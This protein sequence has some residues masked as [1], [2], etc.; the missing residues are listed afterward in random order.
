ME[1]DL[2]ETGAAEER[3]YE[4]LANEDRRTVLSTLCESETTMSL[5]ELAAELAQSESSPAEIGGNDSVERH[6]IELYHRHLPKLDNIGL[7]NFDQDRR[8]VSLTEEFDDAE[9]AT[10]L[11]VA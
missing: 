9:D 5:S 10:G 2:S 8:L 6:E 11:L 1:I 3:C 7:V 4:A